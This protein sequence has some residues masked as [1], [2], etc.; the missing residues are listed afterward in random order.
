MDSDDTAD[1]SAECGSLILS[2]LGTRSGMPRPGEP[3][4]GYVLTAGPTTMLF[5]CGPGIAGPLFGVAPPGDLDAVF[6]SHL[7]ADH[8]YDILP[9]G[10]A[11]VAPHVTYPHNGAV[12]ELLA[13][14]ERIPL[15]L[16]PGATGTLQTLQAMFPVVSSPPLDQALELAFELREYQPH[17][18]MKVG[19]CL[20]TAVPARHVV[21]TCGFRVESAAGTFAYT[22]DTGW[23]DELV[24]LARNADLLLCEAT[25]RQPDDGPHGHLSATQAGQ[26]ATWAGASSLLLTHF[27]STD[28][29]WLEALRNDAA[30]EY[31]GPV[32]LARPGSE[33]R[34][35]SREES[36]R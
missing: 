24:D 2:V 3:S 5:D 13:S 32:H 30:R 16:P 20:I 9:L 31:S 19:E 8:C 10:K 27:S 35:I 28:H 18:E 29:D 4:S 34:I 6:I 7:H 15:Y 33:F 1:P 21:P 36:R 23:T 11:I 22:G 26:L 12:P 25:L 14:P 17:D